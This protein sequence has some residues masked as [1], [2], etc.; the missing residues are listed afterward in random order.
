VPHRNLRTEFVKFS[1]IGKNIS[2]ITKLGAGAASLTALPLLTNLTGLNLPPN[3]M[4]HIQ[5]PNMPENN[6]DREHPYCFSVPKVSKLN[7]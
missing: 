4:Y 6:Q 1:C 5:V 7:K 2:T 3:Q